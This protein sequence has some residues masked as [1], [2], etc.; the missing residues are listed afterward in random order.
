[1]VHIVVIE[2]R[3]GATTMTD[4]TKRR[5]LDLPRVAGVGI[6][7]I[8]TNSQAARIGWKAM[9]DVG[10]QFTCPNQWETP[11]AQRRWTAEAA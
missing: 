1:M 4:Y 6:G 3:N 9:Q 11:K 5:M 8:F 10:L 7:D 2:T